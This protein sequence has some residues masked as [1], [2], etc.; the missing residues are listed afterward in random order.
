MLIFDQE[1]EN[2]VHLADFP[3]ENSVHLKGMFISNELIDIKVLPINLQKDKSKSLRN[4]L[5]KV[6]RWRKIYIE[7]QKKVTLE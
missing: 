5:E 2:Y 1:K 4:I 7:S 3:F 6:G